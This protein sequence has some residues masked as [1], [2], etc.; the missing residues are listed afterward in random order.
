VSYGWPID[1]QIQTV[2]IFW[3]W[4]PWRA[5]KVNYTYRP[6]ITSPPVTCSHALCHLASLSHKYP[7][8]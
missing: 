5:M 7:K 6:P 8:P 4:V 1:L 3:P 2:L